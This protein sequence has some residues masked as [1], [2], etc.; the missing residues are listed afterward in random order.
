M[1]LYCYSFSINQ[2]RWIKPFD[3]HWFFDNSFFKY[4]W[5]KKSNFIDLFGRN[6]WLENLSYGSYMGVI[7]SE[8]LY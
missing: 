4:L 7:M 5:G 8:A 2:Q 3:Y 6:Y 1:A